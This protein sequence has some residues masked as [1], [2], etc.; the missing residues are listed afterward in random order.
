LRAFPF[1]FPQC[2]DFD[3]PRYV[4]RMDN[5]NWLL[6]FSRWIHIT[7]AIVAVGGAAF[8]RFALM[9]AASSTLSDDVH[10]RLREAIRVRWMKLLHTCIALLLITGGLNFWILAVPPRIHP[11]PYLLIFGVKFLSAL[12]VFW[13][14]IGLSSR[15]AAFAIMHAARKKWLGILLA[16]AFTIVLLSGLLSQIRAHDPGMQPAATSHP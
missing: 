11:L 13:I 7:S 3:S 14:A 4:T 12:A 6:L 8:A 15:S 2:D 16:L 9:P 1:E 5:I 10:S